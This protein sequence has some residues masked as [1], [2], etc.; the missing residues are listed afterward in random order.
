MATGPSSRSRRSRWAL[1]RQASPPPISRATAESI[2][3]APTSSIRRSTCSIGNGDGTFQAPTQPS[4]TTSPADVVAADLTGNGIQDLIIPDESTNEV[5]ILLGRGDGSFRAPILIP[6]GKGPSAVAVGDFNG[7]G[8]L[9][10]AVTDEIDDSVSILLGTGNGTFVPGENLDTGIQPSYITAA[11]LT[12]DGHLDLV[13]SNFYSSSISIYYGNGDGTFQSQVVLP[14]RQPAGQPRDRRL[15][16][17]RPARH[18]RRGLAE[19]G[20]GFPGDRP[21]FVT[22]SFRASPPV[23]GRTGWRPA[24]STATAR[25]TWSSPTATCPAPR[26]SG[27]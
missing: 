9:D 2:S 21:R 1:Q 8:I 6:V 20:D 26:M 11:D 17:R 27:S 23:R 7:D 15:Q 25:S 18:R 13:V 22:T 14:G 5:S 4:A 16:R 19:R 3:S 10:L 24:I 12:G